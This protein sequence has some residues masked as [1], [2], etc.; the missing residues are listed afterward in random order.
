[1]DWSRKVNPVT[2]V[3]FDTRQCCIFSL[4][5]PDFSV[6]IRKN[7]VYPIKS[8]DLT[9]AQLAPLDIC[10]SCDAWVCGLE[11]RPNGWGGADLLFVSGPVDGIRRARQRQL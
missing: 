10:V 9:L 1:M 7:P 11:P 8:L 5:P 6:S 4:P 2:C 3:L